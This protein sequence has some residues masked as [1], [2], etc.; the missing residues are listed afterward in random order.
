RSDGRWAYL[1]AVPGN[2][3]GAPLQRADHPLAGGVQALLRR[4]DGEPERWRVEEL[5]R[6]DD[7][8]AVAAWQQAHPLPPALFGDRD[9]GQVNP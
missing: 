1:C 9:S 3:G 2:P 6:L 4:L 5:S 8:G 7:A